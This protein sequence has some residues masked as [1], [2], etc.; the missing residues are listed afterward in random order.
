M[1]LPSHRLGPSHGVETKEAFVSVVRS[2]LALWQDQ[3]TSEKQARKEAP[4]VRPPSDSGSGP[5]REEF[6]RPL[7]EPHQEPDSDKDDRWSIE[8]EREKQDG[9]DNDDSLKGEQPHIAADDSGNGARGA[10]GR[11]RRSGVE[12]VVRQRGDHAAGEVER[13]ITRWT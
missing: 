13:K 6:A 2:M 5:R 3:Q 11:N 10:Q 7:R 4:D 1:L 8:E 9:N 12:L